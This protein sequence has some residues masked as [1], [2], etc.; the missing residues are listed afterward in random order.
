[1]EWL[2]DWQRTDREQPRDADACLVAMEW[3]LKKR[4]PAEQQERLF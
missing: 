2:G 1:M 4:Q 3:W